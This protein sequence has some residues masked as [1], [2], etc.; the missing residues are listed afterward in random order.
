MS[1]NTPGIDQTGLVG[2]GREKH[3][4]S[5]GVADHGLKWRGLCSIG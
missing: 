3:S 1:L 4:F 2:R 5:L